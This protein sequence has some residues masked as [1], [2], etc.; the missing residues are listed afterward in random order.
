M[1]LVLTPGQL[2]HQSE[3]YRQLGLLAQAG[4]GVLPALR[5]LAARPPERSLGLM[6]QNLLARL[7]QG[8]TLAEAFRSLHPRPPDFDVALMEAGEQSGRLDGCFRLL[9]GYYENRAQMARQMISDLLYPVFLLHFAVFIFPFAQFFLTGNLLA[10]L[11]KTL[12]VLLPLYLL[13]FLVIYACQGTHAEAWRARLEQLTRRV[14]L[15]GVAR[16]NLALARLSAALEALISAGVPIF[17]AWELAAAASGS[18][19]LRR[20]IGSWPPQFSLGRTPAD[21][22]RASQ[23]FPS[24]FAGLY[25]SGEVSGQLDTELKHLHTLYL[26]EGTRQMRNLSTW[27]PKIVYLLIMLGI[28]YTVVS[29]WAGYYSNLG[30]AME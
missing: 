10:Y 2:R 9:A 21:L 24:L 16:R 5:Q 23:E 18:P 26:E 29:F 15:L 28:A 8:A 7:E 14:P 17:R 20:E 22:V 4:I 27:L 19:A 25:S 3:F 12:G 1:S 30:R 13:V 11:A 6:A